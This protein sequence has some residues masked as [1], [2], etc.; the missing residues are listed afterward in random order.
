M[1]RL[2]LPR[3]LRE[4]IHAE[5]R[6]A[7][8]RECCGL[9]EGVR[10]GESIVATVIHPTRNISDETDRFEIDPAEQFA[11]LR[12]AR[13]NGTE[14]VGC[15]HSHPN[16]QTTPSACDFIN[17]GEDGF[18]WLILALSERAHVELGA[19]IVS[20]GKLVPIACESTMP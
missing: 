18:V 4:Q 2:R 9:I 5:A 19:F 15:Y 20:T 14:I 3:N 8:P 13:A 16:G 11:I 7:L 6:A 1:N 12:S 17:V 10:H